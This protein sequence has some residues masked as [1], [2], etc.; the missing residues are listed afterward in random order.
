MKAG[1][2]TLRNVSLAGIVTFALL[3]A[4][5]TPAAAT[6][7]P[8][9]MSVSPGAV[10]EGSTGNALTFTYSAQTVALSEGTLKVKIPEGW[11]EPQKRVASGP[12]YVSASV[13]TVAVSKKQITVKSIVLC[14]SCSATITYSDVSAPSVVG[15]STFAA[16]AGA[17]GKKTKPLAASPGVLV[18]ELAPAPI[19]TSVAPGV[20]QLTVVFSPVTPDPGVSEYVVTCGSQTEST[21]YATPVT[22]SGLEAGVEVECTV[23]AKNELGSG[24]SATA[25]PGT[26][27]FAAPG[28]PAINSVTVGNGELTVGYSAPESGGPING[29]TAACG[30][31][32][33]TVGG[34]TLTATVTGLTNGSVY[35]CTLLATGPGGNGSANG[36]VGV[37]G[38]PEAP[39][40]ESVIPADG[41]LTVVYEAVNSNESP[42]SYT[43]TCG[44]QSV[45]VNASTTWIT[46]TG[47]TDGS[48]YA[49]TVSASN[50]AG[51]GPASAPVSGVP[52]PVSSSPTPSARGEFV[53]VSCPTTSECVAVGSGGASQQ[54]GL[55][56]VSNDGGVM[57]TDE[58]IPNGT[59]PL[60]SVTC[61]NANDCLAVGG[62]SVL[63]TSDGGTTW[64]AEYAQG[65]LS[66]VSCLS[67]TNCVAVGWTADDAPNSEVMTSDGGVTWQEAIGVLPQLTNVTC[68]AST[69]IG[70]GPELATSS[71]MGQ[72]WQPFG[73]PGGISGAVSSIACL[74]STT[75]CV[76]VGP[77]PAGLFD[78]SDPALAFRT[79][80]DG[81]TWANI[82]SSFPSGSDTIRSITCPT[83]ET[84][85][86]AGYVGGTG[87]STNNGG[88]TWSPFNDP[89]NV[90]PASLP[91]SAEE[92]SCASA[93]TCV[94]VGAG[95]SGPTAAFTTDGAA[96][97][98]ATTTIG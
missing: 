59:Q 83:S 51:D 82:S 97:W 46:I 8:G 20:G 44:A 84:C 22:I 50:G 85:Y 45:T 86:A 2:A 13:G 12:G 78:P 96:V 49:C 67:T 81:Q 47:L 35:S 41:Q 94:M 27:E 5:G 89:S 25:V 68:I 54:T 74:P 16:S 15:T 31:D 87:A 7:G 23:Y 38:R 30:S 72:T 76:M 55:I 95:S 52:N 69:C 98:S 56:E 90:T 1:L 17:S 24:P 93:S 73:V 79:T 60:N 70:V 9:V 91:G 80:D 11:T 53:A 65:P 43:G 66:S 61:V 32:S 57:F 62:S 6:T 37:P 19:I 42:S 10:L 33:T 14:A 39:V 21:T 18:G 29:Y 64:H 48:S 63:L 3:V 58:P 75:M 26:P 40:I 4:A 92:L 34:S 71:D 88:G 36:W 28:E 77:N